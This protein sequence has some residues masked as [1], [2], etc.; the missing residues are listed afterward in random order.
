MPPSATR[1]EPSAVTWWWLDADVAA[2]DRPALISADGE[3][4]S[5]GALASSVQASARY[6]LD[7]GIERTD[8]LALWLPPGT[9]RAAALLA[10]MAVATV[11]PLTQARSREIAEEDLRLLRATRVVV[12]NQPPPEV[13]QAAN[14]LGL[15]V[16]AI[17]PFRMPANRAGPLPLPASDDIALVLQSSGTTS[18]P[19]V[20]PL[21]HANL[22]AGARSVVEVLSLD[23]DDRALAAM[24]MFHVHGIVATLLAP[25]LAGGSVICCR[26]RAVKELVTQLTSLRPTWFSA[27]PT[28]LLALA[29]EVKRSGKTPLACDLRFLRSVTM[30]LASSDRDRLEALFRVPVIEVYGM[31]EASSQVCST[32]LPKSGVPRRPGTVG[33]PAG[34]EVTVLSAAGEP[35][36]PS[37]VGEVAIRGACVTRGYEDAAQSGW[38]RDARG[39]SWFRTGDEGWFDEEGHL[40]LSGRFKEMINRGGMKVQPLRIDEALNRHPAVLE[41]LSFAVPHVTLGEDVAA[42]VVLRADAS[43][44]EEQL[45][46]H[47][48]EILPAHEV[49]SRILFVASLPRGATGK[50]RRVGMA[51]DYY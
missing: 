8:R 30:P 23:S 37:E 7:H 31:T 3:I 38:H 25:L 33:V 18:R 12:G 46:D 40:T 2:P 28:L 21:S 16:I 51:D 5:R 44:D 19:K 22:F 35:C 29:D 14:A 1:Y 47:L 41:S 11:A 17:D 36:P 13:L 50:L 42:A 9:A 34:P 20:I 43:V 32:R 45:R 6:L 48:I 26:E 39:Q 4:V 10:G 15:D 49:P 27:S 24:P